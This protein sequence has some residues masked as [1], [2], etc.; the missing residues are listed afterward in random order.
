MNI[1]VLGATGQIGWNLTTALCAQGHEVTALCRPGNRHRLKQPGLNVILSESPTTDL[2]KHIETA[3]W[4]I[5]AA[6]PYPLDLFVS[7]EVFKQAELRIANITDACLSANTGLVYVSSF[8]TL[9]GEPRGWLK[10]LKHRSSPYF[11]LKSRMEHI[12]RA[13]SGLKR[14]I[15]NPGAV[16]GPGDFKPADQS[17]IGALLVDAI[18]I[19]KETQVNIIDARDLAGAIIQLI[20]AD[21]SFGPSGVNGHHA[22]VS[23]LIALVQAAANI[24]PPPALDIPDS[25]INIGAAALETAANVSEI[26]TPAP[27]LLTWLMTEWMPTDNCLKADLRPLSETIKD[28][29]SERQALAQ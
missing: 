28:C 24:E 11:V 18:P 27:A 19:A 23:E 8:V 7:P 17:L 10:R 4:L 14:I 20:E 6:A 5:D 12:V 9:G 3:D 13:K 29:V 26:Q 25:L 22:K 15:V 16:M 21:K 2:H 1:V